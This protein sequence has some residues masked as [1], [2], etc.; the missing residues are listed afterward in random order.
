MPILWVNLN[1]KEIRMSTV[2]FIFVVIMVFAVI[3]GNSDEG[4]K[5]IEEAEKKEKREKLHKKSMN[6]K[7]LCP[8][9]QEKGYVTTK[10]V[11]KKKGISGAKATGA[12]LTAG[13]SIL[14][15]GL[16]KKEDI[17]EAK[18]SNCDQVWYY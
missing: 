15:T 8:H 12:V 7:I 14:A 16:S 4:K 3:Y 18:C 9:C 6:K 11:K 1:F 2:L 5:A 10:K 17:T 13:V